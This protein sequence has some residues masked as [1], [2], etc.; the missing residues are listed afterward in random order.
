MKNKNA[1]LTFMV[2]LF[3][4][5]SGCKKSDANTNSGDQTGLNSAKEAAAIAPKLAKSFN[6]IA[7]Y[8]GT[9]D[10]AHINFVKEANIWFPKTAAANGFT[11]TST[12]DWSKLNAANLAKYQVVLFLDDRPPK[13]QEAAFKQYMDNGGAWMGFHVCAFTTNSAEW[14]WYFNKFLG[15][16]G[17]KS[18]TWGPTTAVLKCE[19]QT[20]PSTQRL[21]QKFT[22]AVSEW[23]SWT[24]DLRNNPD[25]KILCSIDPSSFP[26][27][28][29]PNQSWYSG[30]YPV[31]WTNKNYK[32]IYAN[33]GH[34]AMDYAANVGKS[35]TFGSETQNKFIIDGLLWLGGAK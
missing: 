32:M 31:I 22:S 10:A 27:G 25:L 17:F 33:F 2:L 30:Y 8:N 19:D 28:T 34:N 16:G 12:N 14:D 4:G 23:Y 7:F 21:P 24:K 13:A 5:L 1:V 15:V 35:S 29:D 3:C 6:V 9:W 20:H 11:Y 26:L 18:N